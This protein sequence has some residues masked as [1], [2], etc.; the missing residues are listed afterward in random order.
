MT[1]TTEHAHTAN[2]QTHQANKRATIR[3]S[4]WLVMR[5]PVGTRSSP[6]HVVV[7]VHACGQCPVPH[8]AQ[9]GSALTGH[10]Q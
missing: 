9:P 3:V 1:Q 6:V 10:M 5:L 4:R 2:T 7:S 8:A